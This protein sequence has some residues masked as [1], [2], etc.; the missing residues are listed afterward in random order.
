MTGRGAHQEGLAKRPGQPMGLAA[1][2]QL[3]DRYSTVFLPSA[4]GRNRRWVGG[5]GRQPVANLTPA[6]DQAI[7]VGQVSLDLRAQ[8]LIHRHRSRLSLL[9]GVTGKA[10]RHD[11]P[12]GFKKPLTAQRRGC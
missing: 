3:I 2:G 8:A 4:S 6:S 5:I 11:E 10:C 1:S 9:V 7:Q 12:Q